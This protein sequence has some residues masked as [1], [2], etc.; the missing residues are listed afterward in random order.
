MCC[1]ASVG[2]LIGDPL[3]ILCHQRSTQCNPVDVNDTGVC[4]VRIDEFDH[5]DV[6]L[7]LQLGTWSTK[8]NGYCMHTHAAL[9]VS[10]RGVTGLRNIGYASW[11]SWGC[12]AGCFLYAGT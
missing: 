3:L 8:R 5:T 7:I 12:P 6:T 10:R 11:G 4:V 2:V 1:S 9:W